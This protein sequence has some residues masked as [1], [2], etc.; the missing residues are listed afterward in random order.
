MVEVNLLVAAAI[1]TIIL[2]FYRYVAQKYQY[3]LSKPVPCVKPTFLLGSNGATIFR[4]RGIVSHLLKLYNAYPDSKV[5]GVYDFMTPVFLIRD[6]DVIKKICVKDFEFFVDHTPIIPKEQLDR[7]TGGQSLTRN[8]LFVLRGQKWRDMRAT[9]SPAFTGSRMRHTFDLVAECARSMSNFFAAEA[10]S[11]KKLEYEMKD[12]FSRLCTDMIA[13]VAFGIEIDSLKN[14]DNDFYRKGT[15]MLNVRSIKVMLKVLLL[16]T[17]PSLMEKLGVDVISSSLLAYFKGMV[18]D[19]MKQREVHGIVRNDMIHMLMEIRQGGLRHQN[20]EQNLKDAGFATVEESSVGKSIHSRLWTDNELI[21]QCLLFYMAGFETISTC[22]TFLTYELTVNREIQDRLYEE[23]KNTDRS[24][25]GKAPTYEVLQRMT[26]M[27]MVVSEGL[28]MWPPQLVSERYCTKDYQ[29]DDE[30]GTRFVIEKGRTV[31]IPIIAIHRDS[32]YYPNPDV[33]DPERFSQQNR[34]GM[35]AVPYIPFS[36]G[37]RNCIGSRLAL[38][39]VK[40]ILYYLL[41]DFSLQPTEKTQIP[42]RL[43]KHLFALQSEKGV[44]LEVKPRES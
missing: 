20:D 37:P 5:T 9:L 40:S 21:A 6:P 26:Y 15:Q 39:E 27:D 23:I 29:Y 13:T 34:S 11:G 28:R 16:F 41:K 36:I 30:A 1:G 42:L 22:L 4:R 19:N 44:W 14:R 32:K 35:G 43:M 8:T 31:A 2:L 33:F 38:M 18:L 25:D 24:L 3:F 10:K 17:M 12:T 7:E